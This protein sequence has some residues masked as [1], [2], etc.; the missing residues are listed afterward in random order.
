M[1]KAKMVCLKFFTKG[2]DSDSDESELNDESLGKAYKKLFG[3]WEKLCSEN[4]SLVSKNK[5]LSVEVK[6]L[7]DQNELLENDINLKNNEI[8]KL[9]KDLENLN[10]NVRMLNPV[11][12]IFEEIQNAGQQGH[13]GLRAS[14][15]Q[16]V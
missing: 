7:T 16:K 11:S 2:N 14:S 3:S 1:R 8:S 10:K 6:M 5:E 13:I 15:S 12:T 4:R 9:T